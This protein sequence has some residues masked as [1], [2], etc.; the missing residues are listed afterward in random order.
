MDLERAGLLKVRAENFAK[1][2]HTR[3]QSLSEGDST[4]VTE[5][6]VY[7][8]IDS[9]LASPD[10]ELAAPLFPLQRDGST[11]SQYFDSV[12]QVEDLFLGDQGRVPGLRPGGE[13]IPSTARGTEAL[14]EMKDLSD[15]ETENCKTGHFDQCGYMKED[16]AV[17]LS[18]DGVIT[19]PNSPVEETEEIVQNISGDNFCAFCDIE[20]TKTSVSSDYSKSELVEEHPKGQNMESDVTDN[21]SQSFASPNH[22]ISE[23]QYPDS[24]KNM[25]LSN[26]LLV[27]KNDVLERSNSESTA[28]A[29]K[30]VVDCEQQ[31]GPCIKVH[32][33]SPL[34]T[35][36]A[37]EEEECDIET[38]RRNFK[39]CSSL[40]T[41]KTPPGT[42]GRKKIVRFA[43]VLGLDLADVKTFLDEVPTIPQS[44]YEDLYDIDHSCSP[45]VESSLSKMTMAP[46]T[47]PEKTLVPLFQEPN[48]QPNFLDRVCH[49]SVC[50]E[51]AYVSD[52]VFFAVS[53][54]VRVKNIDF[55]KS[56]YVRYSIDK[57]RS[58][59]DMQAKYIP[60]SYDGFSDKFSFMLYAHTLVPGQRIEF[61]VR[62]HSA[63]NQ[64]WDSNG[65]KN[66]VFECI[67]QQRPGHG[68]QP[69][70]LDSPLLSYY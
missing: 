34:R 7:Y 60:N 38:R 20:K 24:E 70:P 57:W 19:R 21:N 36:S 56:V 16:F 66:Y 30:E 8:D 37:Q 33:S 32:E 59:S 25:S 13:T 52:Y 42:P 51:C 10:E 62:Y 22:I 53:G 5:D 41:G 14:H 61:A 28:T 27:L 6:E 23:P 9:S 45:V 3:L 39:R 35:P 17:Q 31:V 4:W 29:Q 15:T 64:F 68:R 18:C 40:K 44:A 47:R 11:D 43:D 26:L 2:L 54:V 69:S 65:G 12:E 48:V 55:H 1:H 63:G 67:T 50:L 46:S 58:F 49:N